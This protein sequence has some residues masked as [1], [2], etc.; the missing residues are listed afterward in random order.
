MDPFSFVR[1]GSIERA[2][3]ELRR[4]PG[5]RPIAGGTGLLDLMKLGVEAPTRLVH[6][7]RLPPEQY[8]QIEA[9]ADGGLR[10]GALARNSD[11]AHSAEVRTRFPALAA[12]I[13]SGASPQIRNM[14]TV[15]GNLMQRTRCPYFRDGLSP[16]N[17]R[18]P[19]SGCAALDGEDRD[20]ALFGTSPQCIATHPSDLC[21]ALLA[22]DA[23][24][25]VLG[26]DGVTARQIPIE[27][28]H[29]L[30]GTTPQRETALLPGELIVAVS[31]PPSVRAAASRYV[32]L[33]DRAEYAFALA[34]AAVAVEIGG[35]AVRSA[36]IALGGVATKPWRAI[37]AEAVLVGA[38]PDEATIA[39]A[40][41][42]ASVGAQPRRHNQF[43]VELIRRC[44]RRAL[45]EVLLPD[46]PVTPPASPT[47]DR[48]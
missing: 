16:C 44:V 20:S 41:Q 13:L 36:R 7:G 38:K 3:A 8:A 6:L 22:L 5:A 31:L 23:Q 12:A 26:T 40:A 35:G 21:V 15:G 28:F 1:A 43:K 10:I 24:V 33:R 39:A 27:A 32:K 18:A 14:A 34:S 48:R 29:L 17:K 47:G 9:M 45:R 2:A 37:A 4:E 46:A 42:A 19:G 11:V 25:H 30:P